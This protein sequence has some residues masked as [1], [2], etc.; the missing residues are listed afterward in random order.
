MADENIHKYTNTIIF[1]KDVVFT[2]Y[3]EDID[4][5][6]ETSKCA[7]S[8]RKDIIPSITNMKSNMFDMAAKIREIET[9]KSGIN[10]E[11]LD[12]LHTANTDI[13]NQMKEY[14]DKLKLQTKE[15]DKR[16]ELLHVTMRKNSDENNDKFKKLNDGCKKIVETVKSMKAQKETEKE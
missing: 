3:D 14:D 9:T 15:F 11:R 7:I 13:Y 10:E 5:V 1:T 8:I 12:K 16:I 4:E 6:D 2:E